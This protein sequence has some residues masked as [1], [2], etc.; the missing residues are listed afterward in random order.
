MLPQFVRIHTNWCTF[1]TF[2]AEGFD[3]DEDHGSYGH[4]GRRVKK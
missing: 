4:A 3:P 2:D 1:M